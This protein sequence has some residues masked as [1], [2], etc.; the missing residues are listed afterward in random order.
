MAMT[1]DLT[2]LVT[3]DRKRNLGE[4]GFNTIGSPRIADNLRTGIASPLLAR[5]EAVHLRGSSCPIIYT[6]IFARSVCSLPLILYPHQIVQS[7]SQLK[8]LR[9]M[10]SVKLSVDWHTGSCCKKSVDSADS[11]YVCFALV[12]IVSLLTSLISILMLS[13]VNPADM[14]LLKIPFL[15]S[16]QAS[17]SAR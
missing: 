1:P 16:L 13:R 12:A 8:G 9:N 2:A 11:S 10:S 14:A 5:S 15:N 7:R 17:L 4:P 3:S 6:K